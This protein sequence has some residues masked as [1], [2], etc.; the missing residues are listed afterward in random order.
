MNPYQ[1][2]S[3][4]YDPG[5]GG[6]HA[7]QHAAT[8]GQSQSA[9][10]Q[11]KQ[12]TAAFE[13]VLDKLASPLKPHVPV[14]GRFLLVVTFL[15]D[16]LRLLF[17]WND[18]LNY[19]TYHR[20]IPQAL[21]YTFLIY[22]VLAMLIGSFMAIAKKRTEIAVGALFSV[23]VLQAFAYGLATEWHFFL[24]NVSIIGGLLMLLSDSLSRRKTL[25]AGLPSINENDRSTYF[26]LAGRILLVFLFLS[27]ILSDDLSLLRVISSLIGFIACV[28]VVVGFKAKWSASFLVIFLS[29]F[30]I[31]I[32]NWW[33]FSDGHPQRD[34]VKY[35]FFQILSI[36]GGLLLLVNQ[37]P[38]GLSVDEK[39]KQY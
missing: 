19:L 26:Q 30:N 14:I 8:G 4:A 28:M 13:D 24:R 32:N 7:A 12:Y 38:G 39:K 37:G 25:F 20:R 11:V 21:V 22:N 6:Q 10:E 29:I 31:V 35:D 17:Q 2:Q 36:V 23:V 18:Q 27:F 1:P 3:D 33:S 16:A 5:Y 15:E 9:M 34:F